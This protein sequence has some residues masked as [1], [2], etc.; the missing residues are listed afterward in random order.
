[1]SN[2]GI[3]RQP[4]QARSS[5]KRD[6]ILDSAQRLIAEQGY[7]AVTV[8]DIARAAGVTKQNVYQMFANKAAILAALIERRALAIDRHGEDYLEATA[9]GSWR[10]TV[11]EGV[12]SFYRLHKADPS[13]DP[14]FIA[15]QDVAETRKLNFDSMSARVLT[16]AAQFSAVTGLPNDQR[17]QDFALVTMLSTSAVVRHALGMDSEAADRV[18]A[19]QV[20]VTITRLEMMGAS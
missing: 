6:C 4:R 19:Q 18:L 10:D 17:M 20:E 14:L 1:L 15:G 7:A 3:R 2:R 13:L 5:F 8:A 11:R 16:A 9:S 12:Y